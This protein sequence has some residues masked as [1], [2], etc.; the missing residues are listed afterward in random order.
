MVKSRAGNAVLYQFKFLL[1]LIFLSGFPS[2]SFAADVPDGEA[3]FTTFLLL[4]AVVLIGMLFYIGYAM[5][6]SGSVRAKNV[7]SV[8]ARKFVD[9]S[10]VVL[11]LAF[12]AYGLALGDNA[13]G[14]FGA[15]QFFFS[16][17][18]HPDYLWFVVLVWMAGLA[19]A[20]FYSGVSERLGLLGH[21]VFVVMLAGVLFPIAVSW[22]WGGLYNGDGWLEAL[23]FV[24]VGGATLVHSLGGWCALAGMLVLGPRLGKFSMHGA[25]HHIRSHNLP[26]IALGGLFFCIGSACFYTLLSFSQ[27]GEW[28]VV[29]VNCLLAMAAAVLIAVLWN[30]IRRVPFSVKKVVFAAMGAVVAVAAGCD[31]FNP[32]VAVIVGLIAGVFTIFIPPLMQ[33]LHLDDPLCVI[34]VHLLNGI[35]G[36]L[37]VGV[38]YGGQGSLLGQV[39]IQALGVLVVFFLTF[40]WVYGCFRILDKWLHLRVSTRAEQEGLDYTEHQD[41]AY[42][43]FHDHLLHRSRLK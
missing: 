8:L 17:F 12:F 28:Q 31:M 43:D 25:A 4:I 18:T 35:W 15:S 41:I 9:L 39:L 23:G 19:V 40:P 20:V 24:D 36:T 27:K 37:A 34:P 11:L 10:L 14:F 30:L 3:F 38:F 26:L 32:W 22:I 2:L 6:Q 1:I 42:P 29:M 21:V 13:S 33:Q 7:G 16:Q 5:M